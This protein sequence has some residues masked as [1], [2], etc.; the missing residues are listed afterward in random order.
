MSQL[1]TYIATVE[2]EFTCVDRAMVRDRIIGIP[3]GDHD[4]GFRI[5][6]VREGEID[7]AKDETR[8]P[9]YRTLHECHPIILP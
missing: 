6:G 7:P 1:K 2:I 4:C 9:E 8:L 5:V 3:I